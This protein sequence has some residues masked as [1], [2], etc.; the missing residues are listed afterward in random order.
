MQQSRKARAAL[1]VGAAALAVGAFT[2]AL[3]Q[4]MASH[5]AP[6]T[7]SV[8]EM[9]LGDTETPTSVP[10]AAPVS[11]AAPDDKATVP[12]GFTSSC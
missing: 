8:S 6:I 1:V 9:T 3:G 2:A 7:L 5:P 12:C 4:E 10:T 11:V